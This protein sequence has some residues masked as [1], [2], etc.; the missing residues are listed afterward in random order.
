MRDLIRFFFV[1]TLNYIFFII[2][3]DAYL[4]IQLRFENYFENYK[5]INS[6]NKLKKNR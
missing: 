6:N 5:K 4:E 2:F 3:C 1:Y